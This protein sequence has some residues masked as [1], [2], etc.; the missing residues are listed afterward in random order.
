MQG[1]GVSSGTIQSLA[2]GL[3]QLGSGDISGLAGTPLEK[4]LVMAAGR[5]GLNY[6]S[7]LTGGLDARSANAL[8]AGIVEYTQ[9]IANTGN[10]VVKSQYANL[11]GMTIAD[12]TA[13]LNLSSQD[14][15]SIS[16]NMLTYS[17]AITETENQLAN[18]DKRTTISERVRN[19]LDNYMTTLG[20][21]VAT[22]PTAYAI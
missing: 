1:V 8:L 22:N 3:G 21:S 11:F 19:V 14:L 15:V 18:L 9:E 17:D 12:M 6:G 16:K 4:L 20:Q 10:K 7:L 13:I 2:A 5:K